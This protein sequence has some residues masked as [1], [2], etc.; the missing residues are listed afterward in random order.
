MSEAPTFTCPRCAWVSYHPKDVEF[1]YCGNCQAFTGKEVD[2][3]QAQVAHVPCPICQQKTLRVER[4]ERIIVK[5]L[6]SFSLSGQQM[7]FSGNKVMWPWLVCVSHG[8]EFEE[9]AK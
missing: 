6:G 9:M 5:P 3:L 1:E 7:K 8:C 2:D 4:R